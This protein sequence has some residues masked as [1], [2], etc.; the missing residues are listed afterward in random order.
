M[1]LRPWAGCPCRVSVQRV[2]GFGAADRGLWVDLSAAPADM[3]RWQDI[4]V[5]WRQVEIRM[6]VNPPSGGGVA[7]RGAGPVAVVFVRDRATESVIRQ[8]LNDLAVS[9]AEFRTGGV[10][11]AIAE[12]ASRPPPRLLIVD[13]QG[14]KNPV[15]IVRD[16]A[17]TC[18][19]RTGLVVIGE[20][21]DTAL[22]RSLRAVGVAEYYFKPLVP[23]LL[24]KTCN[25][26]ITGIV[27]KPASATGKLVFVLGVCGGAGATTIAAATAWHVAETHK[28]RVALLDLDLQFGSA[29]LQLGAAPGHALRE[30]LQ[31]PELV[32]EPFLDRGMARVGEWLEVMAALESLDETPL[33]EE[34]AILSLLER[35][36]RRCRYVFIDIPLTSALHLMPVLRLPGTLLLVSTGTRACARDIVRLRERIGPNN[37]ERATV[38]I[39][40]KAAPS[41]NLSENEFARAAGAPPDI[42][43]PYAREITAASHLG[44]RVLEK[45]S[46]LQRGL[47]PLYR[48]ISGEGAAV[49]RPSGWFGFLS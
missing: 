49:A 27:E 29:A 36:Q 13:V 26:I 30:A 25:A 45:C 5:P 34:A 28:R 8:C 37:A 19:G 3:E 12:V 14:I 10:V 2:D 16:L 7:L 1:T 23:T 17:G 24:K 31:H 4:A 44:A 43:I 48:Q 21:N 47:A 20:Y 32:D 39:L 6:D 15:P 41:E 9:G 42:V 11:D 38:H 22:Y 35:L 40:N 18:K 46:A 33:P